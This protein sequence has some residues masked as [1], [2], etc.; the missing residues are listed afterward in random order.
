MLTKPDLESMYIIEGQYNPL[1]VILSFIIAFGASY[2]A[3]YINRRIKGTGFFHKNLWLV[4]ASLAMGLGIWSMHYVGMSA[5]VTSLPMKHNLLLTLVSVI[6]AVVASYVAF[7]LA[8]SHYKKIQTF[9]AAGIFMGCG[10]ALMHYLGMAAM[11]IDAQT[12]YN[13]VLFGLSIVIAIVASF[14]SL[15]IFSISD[16]KMDNVWVK[17]MVALLMATAVTSMHYIGMF[18]VDFYAEGPIHTH[19]HESNVIEVVLYVTI[20]ISS[21]FVL[22][23]LASRLDKYVDYRVK[24]FDAFTQLPNQNQFTEDQRID[25][26]TQLVAIVHIHNLEKYISAYGYTFGDAIIKSVL[27]LMQ[28]VLPKDTKLYRTEANRFTVVQAPTD[29]VQNT[30]I[31]L[32]RICLLL[33]RSLV[34]N[35][36]MVTVEMVCAV[37][38]SDEKKAIHEHFANTIAVLQAPSTQYKYELIVYNPKIHT[39]NFERQLSLDIQKAMDEDELFIVYQPKVDPKENVLV[40]AEA[41]IRWKHPVFGMVS[42]AVF[43]PILESAERISDVTDWLIVRVCR[44]L[45]EWNNLGIEP[46]QVSINIPGMYLTSPR[47]KSVINESLL[48]YHINPSQIELEITETSVIHDIHNAILAVSNF[49]KK[50]LSVAL[51]DFGTGLS[52]LSYLKE[53]PIST[54]KIDKSFVDGVPNST[55]DA[56]ILKSIIHLCYSLDLTVVIEGVEMSDQIRFIKGLERVPIVQGY[57]YSKPLTVEQYEHWIKEQQVVEIPDSDAE[58][59]KL[60]QLTSKA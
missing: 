14:A 28:N 42:P 4:L 21:L 43:I 56:S 24:N 8:N 23:Y 9:I 2:T 47:L 55:K 37:S 41:L 16:A 40:G 20:G 60:M 44:Q 1:I 48:D 17:S 27:E 13:P 18:A 35:E 19:E 3:V 57:Y 7:Y 30:M 10:I 5:Y 49:R 22:A 36:R 26:N 39:F 58:T 53:I 54:I 45:A 31:A 12:V 59:S 50:G 38:Q 32:E 52:S 33:Q 46:P 29:M 25:K 51:D 6:P 11:E 15:Y 34:V